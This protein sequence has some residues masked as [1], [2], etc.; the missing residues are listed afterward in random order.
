MSDR[1]YLDAKVAL[2]GARNLTGAGQHYLNLLTTTGL[3]LS[4]QTQR[5]PWGSDDIGQAFESNYRPIEQQ[6]FE[7]WGKLADYVMELGEAVAAS[8]A[9]N[10][11]A[12][13]ESGM[14]VTRAYRERP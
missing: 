6:V 9:D 1:L 10:Q 4:D 3:Q 2:D 14:R 11:Q 12:D 8:V 13:E 7:A 5:R